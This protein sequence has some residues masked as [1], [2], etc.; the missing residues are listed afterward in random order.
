MG[1]AIRAG[2]TVGRL[3]QHLC[4]TL[5]FDSHDWVDRTGHLFGRATEKGNW[6]AQGIGRVRQ[7][8]GVPAQ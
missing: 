1:K 2:A 6:R 4:G 7:P 5:A 3:V 8:G